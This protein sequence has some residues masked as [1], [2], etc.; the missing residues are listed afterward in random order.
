MGGKFAS[1]SAA[2]LAIV[3]VCLA[4]TSAIAQTKKPQPSAPKTMTVE[5]ARKVVTAKKDYAAPPR[6]IDDIA[7]V[8]DQYKP[9]PQRIAELAKK[10]DAPL[11]DGLDGMA[12]AEF[13]AARA[14]AARELGRTQQRVVDFRDAYL[15]AKPWLLKKSP[16]YVIDYPTPSNPNGS[17]AF[18]AFI[19]AKRAAQQPKGSPSS[20]PGADTTGRRNI[21]ILPK[22]VEEANARFR[23][24][25]TR[26]QTRAIRIWQNYLAAESEAG[27]LKTANAVYDEIRPYVVTVMTGAT[28]YADIQMIRVRLRAGDAA[29]AKALV[30]RAQVLLNATKQHHF[31]SPNWNILT[32]AVEQGY[33]EILLATGKPAEAETHLRSALQFGAASFADIKLWV[34]PPR[35]GSIEI[36]LSV[37]RLLLAQSLM[38]QGKLIE[39]EVEIRHALVDFLKYQGAD[40]PKTAHTVISLADVLQSQGRY[41]DAQKLAEIA[42]DIYERAGVEK[43]V[44]ADALQRIAVGRASRGEWAA[45][46]ATYDKL[47]AAVANDNGQR[48]RYVDT[49]LDLAVALIR[50]DQAQPAISIIEGVIKK[51]V[52]EQGE[53]DYSVAEARGFLATS[54]AAAGRREDSIRMFG[55]S[56]P[57]LLAGSSAAVKE[58]GAVDEQ[59]RRQAVIDG[60]F[61][62]LAGI[63]GTD[64]ETRFGINAINEAFRMADVANAKSVHAAIAASSARAASG[65]GPL[66]VLIRQTQDTDRQISALSDLLKSTIEAPRDQQDDAVMQSLRKDVAQLKQARKTLRQEIERR[67]P[68]YSELINP[69]PVGISEAQSKL[70]NGEVLLVNQF[71]GGKGYI[72]AIPK[73]GTVQFAETALPQSQ[74]AGLVDGLLQSVSAEVASLSDIPPFDVAAAHQL[75]ASLI[76]PVAGALKDAKNI[77][78]VADGALGRLPFS[79]LVTQAVAQPT[80][81]AGGTRFEQYRAVPFLVKEASIASLPSVS[82][83]ISLRS[84]PAGSSQRKLFL[85][86]GDP[87][88]SA[89]QMARTKS[90]EEAPVAAL[91]TANTEIAMRA[92]PNTN[93]MATA[94]LAQLPRLPDTADE[95]REVALALGADPEA[96]VILGVDANEEKI[97][98]MKLDDRRVIMFATHGLVPG[99]LDGLNQPALA[100]SSPD[101]TGGA[102]DGLLTV[103]KILGLKLN[104]DWV[105]LSACN[106]AAGDG[107]GAEAVS[108]LGRAFFYAG[109]RA[110]L[111]THWPVE[112]VSARALTTDLFR[113]QSANASLGRAQALR[114]AMIEMIDNGRRLDPATRQA[115]FSYAHPMFWA[116]FALIG[117]GGGATR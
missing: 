86:F 22:T 40:G 96:D 63:N 90:R 7:K 13:L 15:T 30:A 69:K 38:K 100:L 95:V 72:W 27:D 61:A 32:S 98:S 113:R 5:E 39:S 103:E 88:F 58:D 28:M 57:T 111:A 71:S 44:H 46:M 109:A 31:T 48:T 37:I 108:G 51:R 52:A 14:L 50:N 47:R 85:G 3:S 1:N 20:R 11:P 102:G 105:V 73:Q 60:Y 101:V 9:D 65:D 115:T 81:D 112:T 107:N 19:N 75:Y 18:Q 93:Q 80:N 97:L 36:Q 33:G 45:S 114:E 35:P 64:L 116:P 67:F 12:K 92:A 59:N 6:S 2:A 23:E 99:E 78:V 41:K 49:N 91:E 10:A 34:E 16:I 24:R 117:D 53:A 56:I 76:G 68:Q 55:L 87:L 89:A 77:I 26:E 8:L 106:T 70:Q 110:L 82:A 43:A 17:A 54:L 4:A 21:D 42:L 79:M 83:L 25:I 74:I 84:A 66:A 62:L 29:G 94:E 104:A